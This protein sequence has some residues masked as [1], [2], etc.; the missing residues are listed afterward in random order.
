MLSK[1]KQQIE[2]E[3]NGFYVPSKH[4]TRTRIKETRAATIE[5][6]ITYQPNRDQHPSNRKPQ[7]TYGLFLASNPMLLI[8]H[9][10]RTCSNLLMS[11]QQHTTIRPSQ[12][13]K[14]DL[15]VPS[16]IDQ[17]WRRRSRQPSLCFD[18]FL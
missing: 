9:E 16:W 10:T 13:V 1:Q 11:N 12:Q 14:S 15:L 17:Q 7:S 5:N 2:Q 18:R 3:R 4:V 8:L 6:Y